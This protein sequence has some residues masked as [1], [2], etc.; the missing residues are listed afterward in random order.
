[1]GIRFSEGKHAE[2]HKKLNEV[3]ELDLAWLAGLL[4]GEASFGLYHVRAAGGK[5]HSLQ[6]RIALA[7]TDE[8]VVR[9]VGKLTGYN[10][11]EKKMS[12]SGRQNVWRCDISGVK[13]IRWMLKL[14]PHLGIRRKNKVLCVIA[15]WQR[16]AFKRIGN[17]KNQ[18]DREYVAFL[19][20]ADE[21]PKYNP[22]GENGTFTSRKRVSNDNQG[23]YRYVT[24]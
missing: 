24:K 23:N 19:Y 4:E 11:A 14:F 17:F 12:K 20:G 5:Y 22:P 8:D 13:A 15:E 6:P 3:S 16:W 10:V 1:M 21:A 7:M 9:R 2:L 18:E